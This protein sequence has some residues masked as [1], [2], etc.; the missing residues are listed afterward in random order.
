VRRG[1][2]PW[3]VACV[4]LTAAILALGILLVR[5]NN[6]RVELAYDLKRL[7]SRLEQAED[8]RSKLEVERNNL[9][10]HHRLGNLAEQYGLK[11]AAPGQIRAIGP[12]GKKGK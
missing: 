3:I 7:K 12:E 11:P 2:G 9:T 8:L 5:V 6:D 4:L 1:G 10:S